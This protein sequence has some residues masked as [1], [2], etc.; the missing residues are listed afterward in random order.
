[1]SNW[2]EILGVKQEADL[3]AV[4]RAYAAKLKTI[5]QDEDPRA[6][7]ELREAYDNGVRSFDALLSR[8]ETSGLT[9]ANWFDGADARLQD[10][11]DVD[12]EHGDDTAPEEVL[13]EETV[14]DSADI[15]D[16]LMVKVKTL[17]KSPAA[18][19]DNQAWAD[20]FDDE[21]LETIDDF[22][23]FERVFMDYLVGTTKFEENRHRTGYQEC[24]RH[25]QVPVL[26]PPISKYVFERMGWDTHNYKRA[27]VFEI[28][29]LCSQFGV[30]IDPKHD[31]YWYDDKKNMD[32]TLLR[33]KVDE[34]EMHPG[35]MLIITIIGIIIFGIVVGTWM[36]TI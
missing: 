9:I 22:S 15:A 27:D 16:E 34:S 24:L 19:K 5:R 30:H 20:I 31:T 8:T 11:S 36:R 12:I 7:M 23:V 25:Y 29:W 26:R 28:E 13:P 10:V 35:L 32:R 17:L 3:R 14:V 1:M 18:Q 2:W 4:K 33:I 6:F 21:R